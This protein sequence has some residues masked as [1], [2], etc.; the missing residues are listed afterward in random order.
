[1]TLP[2]PGLAPQDAIRGSAVGEVSDFGGV[3]GSTMAWGKEADVDDSFYRFTITEM[4]QFF[5]LDL[6]FRCK[7]WKRLGV[8]VDQTFDAESGCH[9]R[10]DAELVL[11]PCF[12]VVPMG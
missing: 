5:A 12:R 8:T 9:I 1:M 11:Y 4:T 3:S 10:P 7:A 2:S 6:P